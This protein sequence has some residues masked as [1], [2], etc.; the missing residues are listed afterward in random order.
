MGEKEATTD[1]IN[2][3]SIMLRKLATIAAFTALARAEDRTINLN[4]TL[5]LPS[6]GTPAKFVISEQ[7][8]LQDS[9]DSLWVYVDGNTTKKD[10]LTE[11]A[12]QKSYAISITKVGN[13]EIKIK[14]VASDMI[15]TNFNV[16][17]W[18]EL[19]EANVEFPDDTF[20][21]R[22]DELNASSEKSYCQVTNAK[23]GVEIKIQQSQDNK[24]PVDISALLQLDDLKMVDGTLNEETGLA[25]YKRSYYFTGTSQLTSDDLYSLECNVFNKVPQGLQNDPISKTKTLKI[26]AFTEEGPPVINSFGVSGDVEQGKQTTLRCSVTSF[27]KAVV[28]ILNLSNGEAEVMETSQNEDQGKANTFDFSYTFT[29]DINEHHGDFKCTA[30]NKVNESESVQEQT[31]SIKVKTTTYEKIKSEHNVNNKMDCDV[32]AFPRPVEV[33]WMM[34]KKQ[35]SDFSYNET[36]NKITLVYTPTSE[37]KAQCFVKPDKDTEA[38][39]VLEVT[40]TNKP[41]LKAILEN[42]TY[43]IIVGSIILLLILSIMVIIMLKKRG[44]DNAPQRADHPEVASTTVANSSGHDIENQQVQASDAGDKGDE[45]APLMDKS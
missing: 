34:G 16:E 10:K 15:T 24:L 35:T 42:P 4:K 33:Y 3:S 7:T 11:P 22:K 30:K 17:V 19:T 44:R 45:Q 27:P 40:V 21:A 13:T 29:P 26:T 6:D 2:R 36:S 23:E 41:A 1:R 31:V 32:K 5:V 25:T 37:G 8:V 28:Q 43:Y 9:I 12:D 20:S 18:S 38:Q 39:V 14:E